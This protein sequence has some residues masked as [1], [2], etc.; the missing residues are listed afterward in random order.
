MLDGEGGLFEILMRRYNERVFRVARS[1][2]KDDSEAEDVM[3]E[4]YV[5]AYRFLN[6][7]EGRGSFPNW[8]SRIAFHEALS[9]LKERRRFDQIQGDADRQLQLDR[10]AADSAAVFTGRAAASS[11][12]TTAVFE[13]S[14]LESPEQHMTNIE[15]QAL[16]S[17]S[18]EKLPQS[19]RTVF[20]LRDVE[21]M[22]TREASECLSLTQE[23]VKVLLHRAR[24]SLRQS[25]DREIGREV[26]ML[27][28]FH[29][30]RCD[31]VVERVFTRLEH[32]VVEN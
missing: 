24:V 14:I 27:Y 21:G 15:L 25:I 5:R 17:R 23:N 6:R 32:A 19:Q 13:A 1:V 31:E 9:R 29:L 30:L 18:L 7:F 20:V 3:Q 16:L 26:R 10:V 4:T 12:P 2:L 28:S 8:L 11:T 22:T